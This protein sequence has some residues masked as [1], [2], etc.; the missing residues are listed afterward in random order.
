MMTFTTTIPKRRNDG[1]AVSRKEM[2]AIFLTIRERFRGFT[3]ESQVR[4][5]WVDEKDGKVYRDA[6][7]R[8]T[9]ACDRQR[10]HEAEELVR[11][12]GRRLGQKAM[13]FEVHGYDGAGILW[14]EEGA[15]DGD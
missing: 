10:L 13:Y 12:I 14:I 5:E 9:V 8:V 2:K 1:S 7:Y 4:G 6:S 11:E 3:V 15:A